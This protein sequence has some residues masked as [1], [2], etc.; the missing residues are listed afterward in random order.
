[1]LYFCHNCEKK[2]H[3]EENEGFMP[4][5]CPE[6]GADLYP[7]EILFQQMISSGIG[8]EIPV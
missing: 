1:M 2:I 8:R 6:C 7:E 4:V 5:T 3:Q